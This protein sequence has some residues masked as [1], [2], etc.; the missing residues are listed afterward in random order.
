MRKN[1]RLSLVLAIWGVLSVFNWGCSRDQG[2]DLARDKGG[3]ISEKPGDISKMPLEQALRTK[4][5]QILFFCDYKMI[6]FRPDPIGGVAKTMIE[7]Q[8]FVW[9]ILSNFSKNSRLNLDYK[10]ENVETRIAWD[11]EVGL[12]EQGRVES[13]AKSR[14]QV[15]DLQ[16][17][18]FL[19]GTSVTELIEY[20]DRGMKVGSSEI[21]LNDRFYYDRVPSE[22]SNSEHKFTD[23]SRNVTGFYMTCK[24]DAQV[25]PGFE[26]DFQTK[27][28]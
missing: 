19:K 13:D 22:V 18:V 15:Y 6:F 24:I 3:A 1:S 7:K 4:Y 12:L 17:A 11:L 8:F 10:F 20:D 16:D 14:S 9:D 26:G 2:A 23:E 5:S 27:I 25:N 21:Y 28:Q